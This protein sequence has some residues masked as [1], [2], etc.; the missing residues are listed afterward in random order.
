MIRIEYR[1]YK[2]WITTRASRQEIV[3][4]WYCVKEL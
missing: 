4:N 2:F 3:I 1:A